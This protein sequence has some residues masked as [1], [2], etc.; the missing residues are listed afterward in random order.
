MFAFCLCSMHIA[1][2]HFLIP[3]FMSKAVKPQ[4]LFVFLPPLSQVSQFPHSQSWS[5][6]S[7]QCYSKRVHSIYSINRVKIVLGSWSIRNVMWFG[8]LGNQWSRNGLNDPAID[9]HLR[10][11]GESSQKLQHKKWD[12]WHECLHSCNRPQKDEFWPLHCS[13]ETFC[14]SARNFSARS[15]RNTCLLLT[16]FFFCSRNIYCWVAGKECS[17]GCYFSSYDSR[18]SSCNVVL[19]VHRH[20]CYFINTINVRQDLYVLFLS[21]NTTLQQTEGKP[22]TRKF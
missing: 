9:G 17:K 14:T 12:L 11:H 10:S 5:T 16:W 15:Y 8:I 7:H 20:I 22:S 19:S 21:V 6:S 2:V 18:N 4:E 1:I 3:F 13:S